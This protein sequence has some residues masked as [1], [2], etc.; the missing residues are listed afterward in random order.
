MDDCRT[1]RARPE[2]PRTELFSVAVAGLAGARSI[3]ASK[4]ARQTNEREERAS[5]RL[6]WDSYCGV[7]LP[8][9][10]RSC[11][12]AQQASERLAFLRYL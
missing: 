11:V 8:P 2:M 4:Q 6:T 12:V 10:T 5:K 9:T 7:P 3:D 1:R